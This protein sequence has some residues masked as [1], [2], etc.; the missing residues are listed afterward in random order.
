MHQATSRR[1]PRPEARHFGQRP[2]R[3]RPEARHPV[4]RPSLGPDLLPRR[5][6]TSACSPTAARRQSPQPVVKV[7]I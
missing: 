3:P 5:P 2:H 7:L 4:R 6:H 1:R